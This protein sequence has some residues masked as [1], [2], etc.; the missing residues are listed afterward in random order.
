[1]AGTAVASAHL[2]CWLRSESKAN[3]FTASLVAGRQHVEAGW[4][5]G[6]SISRRI[7]KSAWRR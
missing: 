1:M 6:R 5:G 2:P 7:R 4:L 3:A